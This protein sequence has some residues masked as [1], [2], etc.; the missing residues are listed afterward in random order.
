MPK[1][2]S[3]KQEVS[4]IQAILLKPDEKEGEVNKSAYFLKK[5]SETPSK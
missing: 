3:R 2:S 1:W 4:L 5:M